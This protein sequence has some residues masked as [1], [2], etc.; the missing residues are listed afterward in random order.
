[1]TYSKDFTYTI[2]KK[3][4]DEKTN[5]KVRQNITKT[6][7][8]DFKL[9]GF[10]IFKIKEQAGLDILNLQS[11]KEANKIQYKMNEIIS[12]LYIDDDGDQNDK[13]Y[14]E[15]LSSEWLKNMSLDEKSEI[16]VSTFP[17][18]EKDQNNHYSENEKEPGNLKTKA[19]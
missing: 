19:V 15:S 3:V 5:K 13:S 14:K 11:E 12:A 4:L 10:S 8:L 1:M 16:I 2:T 18:T 17:G 9:S 6:E 7:L